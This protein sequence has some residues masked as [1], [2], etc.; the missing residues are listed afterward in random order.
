MIC[1]A[2]GSLRRPASLQEIHLTY[3][4]GPDVERLALTDGEILEAV[5]AALDAQGR[6]AV[7]IEPRVHL[8][9]HDSAAGHFNVLRGV[10]HP[11]GLAGVKVVGDFVNNYK[12]GLPS[13][14][15]V[16]NLFDPVTGVPKAILDA[17][18]LTDMRTGAM[19]ALGGKFLARKSSRI[20][21]H[22]GARGTSYWNVRLLNHFFEFDEIRVHSRRP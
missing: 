4:N 6:R 21:G 17:T 10:V 22:I 7:I 13:E 19:T 8:V 12:V 1:G 18:S 15:A 5:E 16:L 11:L 14:M 2:F 20:L 3:L 9:P